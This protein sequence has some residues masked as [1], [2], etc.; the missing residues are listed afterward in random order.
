MLSFEECSGYGV[1][2]TLVEVRGME[3]SDGWKQ[4]ETG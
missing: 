4:E 1:K 3:R 2:L